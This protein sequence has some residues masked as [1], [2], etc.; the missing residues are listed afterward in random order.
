L[1]KNDCSKNGFQGGDSHLN[2]PV[3]Y[4]SKS[5]RVADVR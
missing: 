4:C 2:L 1:V 3:K 5:K